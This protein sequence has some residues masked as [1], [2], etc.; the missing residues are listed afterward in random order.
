MD[1]DQV[2]SSRVDATLENRLSAEPIASLTD[3]SPH[4]EPWVVRPTGLPHLPCSLARRRN[5][6]G[7]WDLHTENWAVKMKPIQRWGH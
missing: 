7:Q 2:A 5:R 1:K 4:R 3:L 6:V